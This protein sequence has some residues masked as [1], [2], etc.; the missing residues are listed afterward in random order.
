MAAYEVLTVKEVCEIFQIHSATVYKMVKQGKIPSFR[1]GAELRFRTDL[2][3]TWMAEQS[4]SG[5]Q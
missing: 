3:M 4:N 1:I 2:I 5:R